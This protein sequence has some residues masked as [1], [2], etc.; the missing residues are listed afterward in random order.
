M[1]INELA[2]QALCEKSSLGPGAKLS[3]FDLVRHYTGRLAHHIRAPTELFEDSCHLEYLLQSY[4]VCA[5]SAVLSVPCPVRDSHTNLRGILN[6]MFQADDAERVMIE[7]GLL[8]INKTTH[9]FDVF[10]SEYNSRARQVHAEIQVLEHFYQNQLPFVDGD[11][12]IACSKPACLC[13]ELYFKHHPARMVIPSSHQKVWTAWSPPILSAY[14]K[15]D[16]ATQLQKRVLSSMSR[17]LRVHIIQQVMQRSRSNRWHP[18]SRTCFTEICPELDFDSLEEQ[19]NF[20]I[21]RSESGAEDDGE[22]DGSVDLEEGGVPMH[23]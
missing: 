3:P 14:V 16:L 18:D 12:Y 13:C 15:G 22:N 7:D 23:L 11:R 20:S 10:L 17:D 21:R 6:R 19:D 8:Y 9:L 5:V 2:A 1:H 4:T